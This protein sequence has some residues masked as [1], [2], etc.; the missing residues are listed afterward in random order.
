MTMFGISGG[1]FGGVERAASGLRASQAAF[2]VA[3]HNIMNANTEGYSRQAVQLQSSYPYT[4]PGMT[5]PMNPQQVGSGVMIT[6]ITRYREEW[7]DNRAREATQSLGFNE[8]AKSLLDQAEN[9]FSDPGG[10]SDTASFNPSDFG[11][12]AIMQDYFNAWQEVGNFPESSAHRQVVIQRAQ[13]MS[14]KFRDMYSGLEDVRDQA[15]QLVQD[16][17][18]QANRLLKEIAYLNGEITSVL[19]SNG[20]P[21]DLLDQRD[22]KVTQLSKM[23]DVS[24]R[25]ESDGSIIVYLRGDVLVQDDRVVDTFVTASDADLDDHLRVSLASKPNDAADI[26]DGEIAGLLYARDTQIKSFEDDLNTLAEEVITQTNTLHNG[27][28]DLTGTAGGDFF[29]PLAAGQNAAQVMTV[30]VTDPDDVAASNTAS[31]SPGDGS[32]AFDH[33][34]L[35]YNR[36]TGLNNQN[37]N[38]YYASLVANVGVQVQTAERNINRFN[39]S[40]QQIDSQQQEISGVNLDEEF[41]NITKFQRAYEAASRALSN[42]DDL[43]NIVINRTGRVGL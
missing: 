19:A 28:F 34:S 26:R 40:L 42:F 21:N 10:I 17:V 8:S 16:R 6:G 27:D 25:E 5:Q 29:T 1:T 2:E 23:M 30:L 18:D 11:L 41:L 31:G 20:L 36:F 22:L 9:L 3:Q 13:E 35:I 24:T 4:S 37:V 15:D 32:A 7:L 33:A 39:A 14:D 38:D 43:L 12:R